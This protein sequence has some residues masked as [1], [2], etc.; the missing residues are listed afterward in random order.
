METQKPRNPLSIKMLTLTGFARAVFF[1][2]FFLLALVGH[3]MASRDLHDNN[4]EK[5]EPTVLH[6]FAPEVMHLKEALFFETI[7]DLPLLLIMFHVPWSSAAKAFYDDFDRI[8]HDLYHSK[9]RIRV[10]EVDVSEHPSLGQRYQINSFPTLIV[11]RHGVEAKASE[12]QLPQDVEGVVKHMKNLLKPPATLLKTVAQLRTFVDVEKRRPANPRDSVVVVGYSAQ[13]SDWQ[14]IYLDVAQLLNLKYRF[15]F[16]EE[17]RV[18]DAISLKEDSL[19]LYKNFDDMKP[20]EWPQTVPF[21]RMAF[22]DWLAN[23]SAPL[24][25]TFTAETRQLYIQR[26]RPI[27]MYFTDDTSVETN[28]ATRELRIAASHWR[29]LSFVLANPSDNTRILSFLGLHSTFQQ[30]RRAIGLI[31]GHQKYRF[32]WQ[33]AEDAVVSAARVEQFLS[34][35]FSGRMEEYH[36]SENEWTLPSVGEGR[37]FDVVYNNFRPIVLNE[38]VDALIMFHNPGNP[39]CQQLMPVFETL[40]ASLGKE[41]TFIVCRMDV[42]ENDMHAGFETPGVPYILLSLRGNK[43]HPVRYVG[44]R[45]ADPIRDFAISHRRQEEAAASSNGEGADSK[46]QWGSPHESQSG[47]RSPSASIADEL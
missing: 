40:A 16:T 43:T 7:D 14:D 13:G 47:R 17:D 46:T 39:D 36:K 41:S 6:S 5:T 2:G 30:H 26:R 42:T 27:V 31:N 3:A 23:N 11:F 1:L 21:A 35:A 8:A 20:Q 9:P 4:H 22:M 15:L 38:S 10:A 29:N 24:V 18:A 34:D 44:P 32:E 37:I 33:S 45:S 19:V 25:G 12:N 28:V